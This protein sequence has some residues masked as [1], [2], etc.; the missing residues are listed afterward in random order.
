MRNEKE[1]GTDIL[2]HSSVMVGCPDLNGIFPAGEGDGSAFLF[3]ELHDSP[4]DQENEQ[5]NNDK[6]ADDDE[7]KIFHQ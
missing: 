2:L 5:E 7:G 3:K 4:D 6:Y 1:E